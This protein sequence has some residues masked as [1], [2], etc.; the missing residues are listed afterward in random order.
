M[1]TSDLNS[2]GQELLAL[3]EK[4]ILF[5]DGAMGTMIQKYSFGESDFRG[6]IFK[7]HPKD[8]KGNSDVLNLTQSEAIGSIHTQYLEAGSDIIETNSFNGTWISQSDYQLENSVRE[9]NLAAAR[10]ARKACDDFMKSHPERVCFVAGSM[11]PTNRTASMSPKVEDPG[12]RN[13][14]F[15]ELVDAYYQQASALVDGGVDILF[16]ETVFDTLN[17]KAAIFAL[18]K[19]FEE[20]GSRWPV[21]IS[22][23][24]S[25]ASGR[26]LS[27]QTMEA[28]WNSVRHAKPI[29]VGLNCAMGADSLRPFMEDLSNISNVYTSCYPNAGLP[30]PLAPSGYDE[31]PEDTANA[32]LSYAKSGFVNIVG[33][34][35]GTTPD[36]IRAIVEKL[37][38]QKPRK[39]SV[40][41]NN[42]GLKLS[43]LESLN[44]FRHDSSSF[45]MV[46]ERT[47]V[48]GSPR[49]LK[50]IQE[51]NWTAALEVARQQVDNGA[52]IIDT[53]FD[54][55][56]LEGESFM[57]HF[58]NLIASEP[59]ISK[60]PLMID[61]SK[62]SVI[63]AGLKCTQGK[64][65]VNS[66][67]LKEGEDV[68]K[69][70]A[71][72]IQRMGAAVIVMAFDEEGQASD[73]T[74][75]VQICQRAYK[76]LTEELHFSPGDIIFD[77]N[78]LTVATGIAEHNSYA[79]DFIEAVTE[80]KKICPGVLT[81][82]GVSNLSFSFRGH[83]KIREA[84]HSVFLY[85]A[86]KAGLD[87]A[88]V[89][90]GMLEVYEEIP[91]ELLT[92]VEDVVLNRRPDATDALLIYAQNIL[93]QTQGEI[94]SHGQTKSAS[95]E[96]QN[97]NQKGGDFSQRNS[98]I[99]T[100][101]EASVEERLSHA[102]VKGIQEHIESDT[103]EALKK[104]KKALDV[105][106][107]PL[108]DGMKHVGK[109]FGE[110]KMFLPQVV[111]SARVMKQAV[112]FLE[113]YMQKDTGSSRSRGKVVM[114]TVKGDV[115]DIGKNIV[116]VVLT[117]NGYE[118]VDLGVM[119]SCEK[120]LEAAKKEEAS[121]IG[122]SGLI[123]PSLDE[124]I[125]NVKE[126]ERR[127]L[128]IPV[129]IGGAT[130][131]QLHTAVKI[132]PHYQGLICHVS[133][134]SLVVNV[135]NQIL[136]AET[137]SS[138]REKLKEKSK[139]VRESYL[140]KERC[141]EDF[142]SLD[143]AREKK[144]EGDWENY[145]PPIPKSFEKQFR[146]VS[147]ESLKPYI[148]WSPFFWAWE[149][150][151]KYPQILEHEKYGEAAQQLFK[152]AQ[153]MYEVLVQKSFLAQGLFQFFNA[154]SEGDD[155]L[156]FSEQSEDFGAEG[157]LERLCFLRQQKKNSSH[158][159]C[160]ADFVMPKDFLSESSRTSGLTHRQDAIGLFVA[161]AGSSIEKLSNEYNK[162]GDDY[163]ALLVKALGDRIAEAMTE[164]L[165]QEARKEWGY[166]DLEELTYQE[167]LEEKYQGIRPA[168]G[169]PAC[170]DHSEKLKIWN[171]LEVQ[172]K[173]GV[174]L[175]ENFAMTPASSVS[176]YYFSHPETKYF[177]IG[178]PQQ[179]Q[180]ISYAK[181]KNMDLASIQKLLGF[182]M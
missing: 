172:K 176:G 181:R 107:G 92:L 60:V 25:D 36:H 75:K 165:H 53:N 28:F 82:G 159:A 13:I 160:L 78:I 151:G 182:L 169:Y 71:K 9:M 22:V 64:P 173:L 112:Q 162:N 99:P 118:V 120:I 146:E 46:G 58:L 70:H 117:C 153:A 73:K 86:I 149:L 29:S 34:C 164:Y 93:A 6:E 50:T 145:H 30:N 11:G 154:R 113:P 80:I 2:K 61:S 65:I 56:M 129:L 14:Q 142:L 41:N 48:T 72:Y 139:K 141:A 31:T 85:H 104:Y 3:L 49:F 45:I 180:L 83:Q 94:K 40:T 102:L 26:T 33:G 10:I 91:K 132:D 20:R 67:S 163:K 157:F 21:M 106:E 7:N 5:L 174:S 179:D 27:G 119:V 122:M 74:R 18:E 161:T 105:I 44:I 116:N 147:L 150:K 98:K 42:V 143:Q 79:V 59:D 68:F 144:Y 90:A 100:W 177:S 97:D 156:L 37:K 167:L 12:F 123:T 126:M 23:T 136:N 76:I 87:M 89:N 128:D 63:E 152:D 88:I 4:K 125:H 115:H 54:A 178:K 52:N 138:Y 96:I 81:I 171:L 170:P 16:P 148:D 124:M 51:K 158:Q 55:A 166:G 57:T 175:T 110:G 130:T 111:K 101:R 109:L 47:N 84:M 19:L 137:G 108:M 134:A 103:A 8:L 114:A 69:S 15:D 95:N 66:I 43:G 127:D 131:S 32:L 135:C 155:I 77:P 62:W 133:D 38:S 35:C 168:P 17:L 121:L 24:V 39:I 1:S 140:Q